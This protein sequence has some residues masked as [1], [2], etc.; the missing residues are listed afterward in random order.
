MLT[1]TATGITTE[2]LVQQQL[3]AQGLVAKRPARDDGV[4]FEVYAPGNPNRVL[5]VQ[6][7]GR[8]AAQTNERYRWFQIRTTDAQRR[9]AVALGIPVEDAYRLKVDKADF[10]VFVSLRYSECWVF[11]KAEV[12][13]LI[14][15]NKTYYGNRRDNRLGVQKEID[16]DVS[17]GTTSIAKEF[18]HHCNNFQPITTA[19]IQ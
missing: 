13:Q 2:A 17:W 3:I 12:L 15:L 8:G 11:S 1:Q 6:V 10:F 18:A 9:R 7:K 16:L 14:E 19:A 4:D 5:K